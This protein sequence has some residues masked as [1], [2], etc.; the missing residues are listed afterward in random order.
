MAKID[1][2]YLDAIPR[3]LEQRTLYVC[4]EYEVVVHLCM[5]GCNTKVV[6]PLGPAEWALTC[7]GDVVSLWPSVGNGALPCRSHYL[8]TRSEIRWLPPQTVSEYQRAFAHDARDLRAHLDRRAP[9][10]SGPLA[11]FHNLFRTRH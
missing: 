5:C 1:H 7:E 3:A 2:V 6:T 9:W 4:L 10:W 8:I 11:W